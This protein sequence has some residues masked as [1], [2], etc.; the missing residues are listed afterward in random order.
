[1]IAY[2]ISFGKFG[3]KITMNINMQVVWDGLMTPIDSEVPRVWMRSNEKA[4]YAEGVSDSPCQCLFGVQ[5][6]IIQ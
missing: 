6:V 1:M 2:K 3:G 5:K 4:S